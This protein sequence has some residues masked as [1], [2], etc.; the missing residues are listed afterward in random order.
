MPTDIIPISRIEREAQQAARQY[1][2]LNAACPYPFGSDA[3]H[4]FKAFFKQARD[5]LQQTNDG[6]PKTA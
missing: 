6:A 2:C 4:M 3:G 5:Q 1:D